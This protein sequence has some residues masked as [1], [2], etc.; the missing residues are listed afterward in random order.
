ML[1]FAEGDEVD[2]HGTTLP[3]GPATVVD[4]WVEGDRTEPDYVINLAGVG[5]VRASGSEL[6]ARTGPPT[7]DYFADR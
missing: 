6:S 1:A 4:V 3:S 7:S 2:Y 5:R